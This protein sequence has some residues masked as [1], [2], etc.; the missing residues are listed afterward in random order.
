MYTTGSDA[1]MR[2][3]LDN[4][5]FR[6]NTGDRVL[7]YAHDY[8]TDVRALSALG[9]DSSSCR[10][11][12]DCDNR[13]AN[14]LYSLA[15]Y[16]YQ[17][18]H[19]FNGTLNAPTTAYAVGLWRW[20]LDASVRHFD[21]PDGKSF[22]AAE[23]NLRS[24]IEYTPES[25]DIEDLV[26]LKSTLAETEIARGNF[27][28]ARTELDRLRS[29]VKARKAQNELGVRPFFDSVHAYTCLAR[30]HPD[31]RNEYWTG[32]KQGLVALRDLEAPEEFRPVSDEFQLADIDHVSWENLASLAA[33][34]GQ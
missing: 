16:E 6:G 21:P 7:A 17:M 22:E 2:Q 18:A 4:L 10:D 31:R 19:Y 34:C 1:A 25:A 23:S 8:A 15:S 14:L 9:S 3:F 24:L 30:M 5:W 32:V 12:S 11:Q 28:G 33:M 27:E 13:A 26:D 20:W 29:D